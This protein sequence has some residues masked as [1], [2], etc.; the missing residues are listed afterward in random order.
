MIELGTLYIAHFLIF[1]FSI[2][3]IIVAFLYFIG[4]RKNHFYRYSLGA[5]LKKIFVSNDITKYIFIFFRILLLFSLAVLSG[6]LQIADKKSKVY[7]QG[8]DIILVMDVSGS[9]EL[10]DDMSNPKKRIDVSK[11]EAIRFI[12]KRP[13]DQIGLVLF[14]KVAVSRCPLTLDK[15]ILKDIIKQINLG[16][17]PHS[18]TVL[19]MGFAMALNRLKSSKAKSKVIILL[20]DGE[21]TVHDISTE[22]PIKI[23]KDLGVKVYTIGVGSENG[24]FYRHPVFGIQSLGQRSFNSELLEY[25]AVETNG[26]F[27]KAENQYQMKQ[28]YVAIDELEK[29]SFETVIFSS[30]L[31]YF[32]PILWF[33]LIVALLE[34]LLKTFV[35][36]RL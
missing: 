6:K 33:A 11:A 19:A 36:F 7:V 17:I 18:G 24:G 31:D 23:A 35:W 26:K 22:I 34:L 30:Y 20:T 8:R 32:K 15:N 21:P 13:D 1:V 25:I 12:D 2:A 5:Y 28:V 9:M 16:D 3:A 4:N 14:G 29:S 27:F 10:F